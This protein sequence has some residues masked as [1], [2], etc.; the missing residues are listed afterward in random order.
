MKKS[1][2]PLLW[3]VIISRNNNA[4]HDFPKYDTVSGI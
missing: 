2:T 1:Y 4:I 3:S